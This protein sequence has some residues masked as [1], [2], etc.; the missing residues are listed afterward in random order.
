MTHRFYR[1]KR[2]LM[3]PLVLVCVMS[4]TPTKAH[5]FFPGILK[6]VTVLKHAPILGKL[7]ENVE[8][9]VISNARL[10]LGR[11]TDLVDLT[12][13][14]M[15]PMI[16]TATP[17][18]GTAMRFAGQAKLIYSVNQLHRAIAG[19]RTAMLAGQGLM[20]ASMAAQALMLKREVE[21]VK[22]EVKRA[23][24]EN[25]T[26][27]RGLS[28][29]I[30]RSTG[31][32]MSQMN[33]L[34]KMEYDKIAAK[35]NQVYECSQK[36][37]LKSDPSSVSHCVNNIEEIRNL[38]AQS[39][40]LQ[41]EVFMLYEL[42]LKIANT[43][44]SE[45]PHTYNSLRELI[46]RTPTDADL[47]T[48]LWQRFCAVWSSNSGVKPF[49]ETRASSMSCRA[50]TGWLPQAILHGLKRH[51]ERSQKL[52][53]YVAHSA[54]SG[55]GASEIKRALLQELQSY[56][57]IGDDLKL[58]SSVNASQWH[59]NRLIDM[60]KH[61][62]EESMTNT[63]N[64]TL[65]ISF[66]GS[67]DFTRSLSSSEA[68]IM[69]TLSGQDALISRSD[70]GQWT[71]KFDGLR[72]TESGFYAIRFRHLIPHRLTVRFQKKGLIKLMNGQRQ[73]CTLSF[74]PMF[75]DLLMKSPFSVTQKT[76]GADERITINYYAETSFNKEAR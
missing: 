47:Q 12:W 3:I 36:L 51:E 56:I 19:L 57:P 50:M 48:A 60:V 49:A 68:D 7:I 6:A 14:Q 30:N 45:N 1:F 20:M 74:E 46:A 44:Y 59:A 26:L 18:V 65:Y 27:I 2:A 71:L 55:R 29:Q 43:F 41:R 16:C 10:L 67:E 23:K 28:Q 66:Q 54:E 75:H 31:M 73:S 42:E 52:S 8:S 21:A 33:E 63:L 17:Y 58:P 25:Y 62:A 24:A 5:A 61:D 15:Y 32:M 13:C 35:L 11:Y 9:D 69:Y 64:F 70:N 39:G 53:G 76:C 4:A 72:K 37:S 40:S 22:E 34:T 38:L